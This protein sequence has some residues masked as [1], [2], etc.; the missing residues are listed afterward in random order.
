[1][2]TLSKMNLHLCMNKT[3]FILISI[4]I[5]SSQCK[6]AE[7]KDEIVIP[8]SNIVLKDKD[9]AIIKGNLNGKWKLCYEQGGFCELC[10]PR[11]IDGEYY[12]FKDGNRII[13]TDKNLKLA[14]SEI[15]WKKEKDVF[16]ENT[17]ILNFVDT[18]SYPY[19]FIVDGIYNDT[20]LLTENAYDSMSYYLTRSN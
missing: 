10:P 20:L 11:I 19:S 4:L 18:R 1:M 5:L 14:D 16:E 6:K 3:I 7:I 9:L 2:T 12:E 13:W 17:F 8:S 15:L